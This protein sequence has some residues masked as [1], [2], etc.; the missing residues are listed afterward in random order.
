MATKLTDAQKIKRIV[1]RHEDWTFYARYSGRYMYG[2]QCPGIVCS[3]YDVSK[4]VAAVRR[5]IVG[6]VTWN[7]DSMGLDTIV[8]FPGLQSDPEPT[9]PSCGTT[10]DLVESTGL[11]DSCTDADYDAAC[12]CMEDICP[13]NSITS[14]G[15][16][17]G[18]RVS[19]PDGYGTVVLILE[20]CSAVVDLEEG[21]TGTFAFDKVRQVASLTV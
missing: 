7:Q 6:K 4:A 1:G 15:F 21:G 14:G 11:C 16:C 19:T 13:G 12:T 5:A 18:A 8:Y 20:D 10:F 2:R 3:H 9:C 17:Q